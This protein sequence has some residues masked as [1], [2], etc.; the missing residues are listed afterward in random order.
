[1]GGEGTSFVRMEAGCE[2]GE[3]YVGDLV[4][5]EWD[6]C[7]RAV[8]RGCVHTSMSASGGLAGERNRGGGLVVEVWAR[9]YVRAKPLG[10]RVSGE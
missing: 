1:V 5:T 6:S 3:R 7:W 2:G 10:V 4:G 9:C 8:P